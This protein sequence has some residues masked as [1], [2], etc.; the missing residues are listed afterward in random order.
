MSSSS[1]S[2]PEDWN[3]LEEALEKLLR[4]DEVDLSRALARL[5]AAV[6]EEA[7]VRP[8]FARKLRRALRGN[9]SRGKDSKQRGRSRSLRR[10][11]GVLDPFELYKLGEAHLRRELG[12]LEVDQLKDIIAEH[13]M[14]RDRLAMKWKTPGRLIDRI[15]ETVKTR[16]SKGAVF[17]D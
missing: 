12:H 11:S 17:R 4:R 5:A 7:A 6:A 10:P 2:S 15:A 3:E 13:G 1:A 14:D 8:S 16:T 9:G